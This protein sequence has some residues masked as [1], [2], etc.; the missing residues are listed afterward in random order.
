MAK[1]TKVILSFVFICLLIKP[2]LLVCQSNQEL[3]EMNLRFQEAIG[4]ME[5]FENN[6]AISILESLE[7]EL[8]TNNALNTEF[9][10]KVQ[11]KFAEALEKE[12]RNEYAIE[13]LFNVSKQSKALEFWDVYANS[14]LSLARLHEKLG[15]QEN[16]IK[17][18]KI[19]ENVISEHQINSLLPRFDIRSS[20]YHRIF[21]EKDSAIYYAYRALESSTEY[22][23]DS[24]IA[25]AHLLL[26]LLNPNESYEKSVEHFRL[27]GEEWAR[28]GDYVG[29]SFSYNNIAKLHYRNGKNNLAMSYNDSSLIA[30][31]KG[32]DMGH[33]DKAIFPTAYHLRSE[34]FRE[35]NML[36][37]AL[38]YKD[39]AYKMEL[40]EARNSNNEKI[41]EID[42]R[43]NDELKLK[44][45]NDQKEMISLEGKRKNLLR[46]LFLSSLFFS[47][48]VGFG[49]FRLTSAVKRI[50]RQRSTIE[51]TN[52]QLTKSLEHSK[53][54]QAELHH[55]V[56]NN[57][58]TIIS[59]IELQK[60]DILD[61]D[62][63]SKLE[64]T[65]QRIHGMA[66]THDALNADVD[67]EIKAKDFLV[68][69]T[70]N[71]KSVAEIN[72]P[73]EIFLEVEDH[74]LSVGTLM[75]LG[76]ILHELLTN[77]VKY[78]SNHNDNLII[79]I[80]LV[81]QG[82]FINLNYRDNGPGFKLGSMKP[83]EGGLGNY[84]LS[85]MI[86][87][88]NGHWETSNDNGAFINIFLKKKIT[89]E[90]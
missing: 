16:C 27:A 90:L 68:A 59:L 20:S 45:I 44:T 2:G 61:P 1:A 12:H 8:K 19:A 32:L 7:E 56:K 74:E 33:E 63:K 47:L 84:L 64:A 9:G 14:Q 40:E 3:S 75:P 51:K 29:L 23:Q 13:K 5:S 65:A 41:I 80:K 42:A 38:F 4:H 57:L 54:L 35:K 22:G 70:N 86:R 15:R 85:S 55:R 81:K 83:R 67:H 71:F 89:G 50:K 87:Q 28:S 53:V 30:G 69:I 10:F 11:D 43:Y 66:A 24:E 79:Q 72:H 62:A 77:S 36:D 49:Y 26:G 78:F 46:T 88:L 39:L 31:K 25:V 21:A 52:V 34:L 60:K 82:D 17:Y 6:Q 37:S 18:L 58:Q 48:L 76:M 73:F